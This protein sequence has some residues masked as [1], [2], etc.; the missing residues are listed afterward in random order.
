MKPVDRRHF[1]ETAGLLSL[2]AFP[3]RVARAIPAGGSPKKAVLISML[4]KE[5]SYRDRFRTH[6]CMREAVYFTGH[7]KLPYLG[8]EFPYDAH[9]IKHFFLLFQIHTFRRFQRCQARHSFFYIIR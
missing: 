9:I 8:I 6:I 5:L 1:L 3:A 4:P 7:P 2:A